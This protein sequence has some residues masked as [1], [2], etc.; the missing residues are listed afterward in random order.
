MDEF[1]AVM[2]MPDLSSLYNEIDVGLSKLYRLG[3]G[4]RSL[5]KENWSKIIALKG[6]I[7]DETE[8]NALAL[9]AA[10]KD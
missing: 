1:K 3:M 5:T 6:S 8:V 4:F 2:A 10:A 9:F 7:L